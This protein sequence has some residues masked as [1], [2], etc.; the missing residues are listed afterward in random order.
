MVFLVL[1]NSCFDEF[2]LNAMFVAKECVIG[3]LALKS[4]LNQMCFAVSLYSVQFYVLKF[5]SI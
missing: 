1:F 4:Y 2:W 5:I 3:S